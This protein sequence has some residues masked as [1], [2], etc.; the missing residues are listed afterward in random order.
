MSIWKTLRKK[1]AAFTVETLLQAPVE[2]ALG[3]YGKVK[4]IALENGELRLT[5]A[6]NGL[7]REVEI[8]CADIDIAADG[9]SVRIGSFR[10]DLACVEQALNDFATAPFPISHS[11]ARA[12]LVLL[13]KLM[14]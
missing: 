6:P 5:L 2:N 12:A 10:S 7:D 14:F 9:S 8:R 13:R 4:G 1:G 11:G 3:R